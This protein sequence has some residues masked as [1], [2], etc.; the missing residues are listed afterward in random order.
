MLAS[1]YYAE[2]ARRADQHAR[3]WARLTLVVVVLAVGC[4]VMA[5]IEWRRELHQVSSPS[6]SPRLGGE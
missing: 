4:A 3:F 1:E 6:A 2:R 5:V